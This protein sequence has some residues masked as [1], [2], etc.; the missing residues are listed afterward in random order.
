MRYE[1]DNF[2]VMRTNF[3]P[4]GTISEMDDLITTIRLWGWPPETAFLMAAQLRCHGV[5]ASEARQMFDD[6][7]RRVQ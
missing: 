6:G 1:N 4:S 2:I 3:A 5:S 7:L